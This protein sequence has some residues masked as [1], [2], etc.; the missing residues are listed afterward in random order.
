MAWW[1]G[2]VTGPL[3]PL[4][5]IHR[6]AIIYASPSMASQAPSTGRAMRIVDVATRA[7]FQSLSHC[8]SGATYSMLTAIGAD[9]TNPYFT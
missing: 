2:R 9:S 8:G 6:L 5:L 3:R 4:P 7:G 1:T